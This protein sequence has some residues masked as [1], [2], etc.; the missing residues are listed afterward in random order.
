VILDKE[1]DFLYLS[2]LV[3]Q[4]TFSFLKI[5]TV[6][7]SGITRRNTSDISFLSAGYTSALSHAIRISTPVCILNYSGHKSHVS[8]CH[9]GNNKMPAWGAMA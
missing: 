4:I 9:A 2:N 8:I 6:M 3:T 7:I 5:I 1:G